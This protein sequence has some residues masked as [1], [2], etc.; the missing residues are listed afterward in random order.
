MIMTRAAVPIEFTSLYLVS[1]N[2]ESFKVV[3]IE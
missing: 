1:V 3:S 2:L